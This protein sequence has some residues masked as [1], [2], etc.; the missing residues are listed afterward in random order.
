MQELYREYQKLLERLYH[1]RERLRR[2]CGETGRRLSVIETEIDELEE[3]MMW[4]RVYL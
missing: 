4:M 3:S 2:E 1:R